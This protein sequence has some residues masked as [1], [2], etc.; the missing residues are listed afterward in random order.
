M[1]F[2]KK[3]ILLGIAVAIFAVGTGFLGQVHPA[4]DTFSHFRLH[5]SIALVLIGLVVLLKN[6]CGLECL[7]SQ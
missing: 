1:K 5:L 6:G 3:L 7:P 4:F 2:F